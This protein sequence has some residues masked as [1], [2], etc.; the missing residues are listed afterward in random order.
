MR[1]KWSISESEQFW[2]I[3][4]PTVWGQPVYHGN[5]LICPLDWRNYLI[6]WWTSLPTSKRPFHPLWLKWMHFVVYP[7]RITGRTCAIIG[8]ECCTYT[9]DES[10]NITDLAAHITAE[11][12]TITEVG[13]E[14]HNFNKG[15]QWPFSMFGGIW[16]MVI[17]YGSIVLLI[18]ILIYVLKC[19]KPLLCTNQGL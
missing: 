1:A 14:M 2:M 5:W 8:C 7:Y 11:I 9:P 6:K 12:K 16:G 17:H 18:I 19:L 13:E 15:R 3:A 10:S 4:F